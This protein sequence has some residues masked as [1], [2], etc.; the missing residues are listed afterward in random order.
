MAATHPSHITRLQANRDSDH[1]NSHSVSDRLYV[2]TEQDVRANRS[3]GGTDCRTHLTFEELPPELAILFRHWTK[4]SD[5]IRRTFLG[6]MRMDLARGG[7]SD[8]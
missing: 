5:P 4:L 6:L 7:R 3:D 2:V 8:G 1:G